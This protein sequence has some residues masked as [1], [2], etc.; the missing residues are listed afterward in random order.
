MSDSSSF[1]STDKRTFYI[2]NLGCAKNQVDAEIMIASLTRDGWRRCAEPE[3]AEVIIVNSCGFIEPAKQESIDTV[4]SFTRSHPRKQVVMAGCLSQRYAGEIAEELPELAGIV[5][6]RAPDRIAEFLGEMLSSDARV[7]VPG[8]GVVRHLRTDLLSLPGSA[9]VKVAEGCNNRCSFCAIPLIRG[10]LRSRAVAEV[11]GEVEQ[12]VD[13]GIREINLVAQDLASFG[14]DSGEN[15]TMLLKGLLSIG[16]GF[17]VRMLYVYPEHFPEE[18]LDLCAGHEQLLPYFDIPFQHASFSVLQ[19]MGR[20]ATARQN[21]DLIERIRH[22]LPDV[23]LRTSLLVGFYGEDEDD[24]QALIEFQKNAAIDWLGVFT[25]SPEDGT[26]A[27]RFE[28]RLPRPGRR[29]AEERRDE[30]L[31]RQEPITWSRVDRLVGRELDVLIEELVPD[32]PLA[33]GRAYAHA[34]DVDG[35]VVVN[36]PAVNPGPPAVNPGPP[37]ANP[38]PRNETRSGLPGR[39]A[40]GLMV[41][42]RIVRRNGLDVEAVPI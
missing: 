13:S 25:Y 23:F 20:P 6:N 17:W 8:T 24:F 28:D 37:A 9:Y 40:P 38:G 3:A 1:L 33:L 42:C 18:L 30:L 29:V 14:A 4:L 12:L 16:S 31:R 39:V 34:P 19:R 27:E 5:G 10:R 21:L 7:F 11:V 36:L 32:E 15:L 22:R 2:E 26:P 41:P 35:A